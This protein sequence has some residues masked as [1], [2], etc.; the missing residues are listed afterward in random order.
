M[1]RSNGQLKKILGIFLLSANCLIINQGYESKASGFGRR[2]SNIFSRAS[3]RNGARLKYSH[4]DHRSDDSK[5][6]LLSNSPKHSRSRF[7]NFIGSKSSVDENAVI[8]LN[9]R[10]SKI[11]KFSGAKL[12]SR[13]E[14][15][16]REWI[17][18]DIK[19]DLEEMK[20]GSFSRTL[21]YELLNYEPD[22]LKRN[23]QNM[24]RLYRHKSS[25]EHIKVDVLV[26]EFSD[27]NKITIR[28]EGKVHTFDVVESKYSVK[29]DTRKNKPKINASVSIQHNENP[30]KIKSEERKIKQRLRKEEIANSLL[31]Y[32]MSKNVESLS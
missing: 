4:V 21:I 15:K 1:L 10:G 7:M 31:K 17:L 27:L 23:N 26:N 13:R 29:N 30:K 32:Y 19:D 20:G 11:R 24:T 8:G 2:I 16:N 9:E 14:I 5:E 3:V 18:N 28:T 12:N 25:D 22:Y 6:L